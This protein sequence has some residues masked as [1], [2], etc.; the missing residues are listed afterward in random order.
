MISTGT[1]ELEGSAFLLENA[2]P[3][4]R[5]RCHE[6]ELDGS[7][8][9]SEELAGF[10][11]ETGDRVLPY[12]WQDI[13]SRERGTVTVNTI[14][15]ENSHV[16]AEFWPDYG[17]RLASLFDKDNGR[18]ILFSN[19][20]LQF[21]NLAIR[22]A[23]FSGGIE[24]NFGQFGHSFISCAPLFASIV[25]TDDG[26]S[27][28]RAYEYERQKGM[29]WQLDFHLGEDDRNLWVY[30]RFINPDDVKKPFYWWTNIAVPE[31]KGM[32]V[33]SGSC[34]V[35][36]LDSV[37][38][39]GEGAKRV[40]AYG[41]LPYLGIKEGVDYS[42]PDSFG[43]SNEYFFQNR[44]DE[45]ETWEAACYPDGWVFFDRSSRNLCYHKM[46]CWGEERGG[47]HWRDYLS[48]EG[49]GDYIE[50][51][52]GFCPT[53]CH[54]M[55]IPASSSIDFVQVFG[56]FRSKA[57]L[58]E[59]DYDI[60]RGELYSD[61][62][63]I[64]SDEEVARRRK[65]YSSYASLPVKRMIHYGSGY[66]A[67]EAARDPSYVP[68]CFLFPADSIGKE[69]KV[70]LDLL[71]GKE[72]PDEDI[73]SSFI[74]DIRWEKFLLQ[75]E[76]KNCTLWNRLGVMYLEN[77]MD[78]KAEDAFR[79]ALDERRNAFSLRCLAVLESQ[80][81]R[82]GHAID[83]MKEAVGLDSRR[84]YAEE[85]VEML[86]GAGLWVEAWAFRESL[87]ED[88]KKD[89]SICLAL[90]EGA[91]QRGMK[92]FLEECF[93]REFATIR[94]GARTYTE[95]WYSYRAILLAEQRGVPFS[96]ELVEDCMKTFEVP[97]KFEFRML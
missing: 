91:S 89:E 2:L 48:R 44:Q 45:K 92:D 6:V 72:M 31:K 54:G 8:L 12:R 93:S 52:A 53:Q 65:E 74:V 51:Q 62:D 22:R 81:G 20:V 90:L 11:Y 66:G 67:L 40:M 17:M 25:E 18:E 43:Y 64:V 59:G 16:R 37:S 3:K 58:C 73:P 70:W 35:I 75:A 4:F 77:E 96:K 27:F 15:M 87:P 79:K 50:L 23:W 14:V 69:E 56:A 57:P 1:R 55:D 9:K 24:W 83:L 5:S 95:S 86:V 84:E 32:R 94:E 61:L 34:D 38:L 19:P 85:Y 60:K 97:Y 39:S 26:E 47:H 30:A 10:G 29:F 49:E 76:K 13:Y 21:G 7:R 42:F 78:S 46:F 68:S 36:F 63:S 28:L 41:R 80:N 88:V 33:F 71:S 82:S